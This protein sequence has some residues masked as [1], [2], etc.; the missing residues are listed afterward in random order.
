MDL[1]HFFKSFRFQNNEDKTK[2]DSVVFKT[3]LLEKGIF[4]NL[5][6]RCSFLVLVRRYEDTCVFFLNLTSVNNHQ[7]RPFLENMHKLMFLKKNLNQLQQ[8][9]NYLANFCLER[10]VFVFKSL[11]KWF[12]R[13]SPSFF[14]KTIVLFLEKTKN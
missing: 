6:R 14:L 5:K 9:I 8:N 4:F 11:D 10:S 13:C 12:F 7:P 1:F 3:I 2:N